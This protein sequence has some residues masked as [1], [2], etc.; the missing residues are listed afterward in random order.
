[1]YNDTITVSNKIITSEDL[2]DIFTK[3]NEQLNH[4][5][6]VND[7]EEQR[8]RMLDHK[9]E[10]WSFKDSHSNLNF[11]INFY[12]S[13]EIKFDNF[14]NFISIY[15][16]RL[17]EIKSIYVHYNLYYSTKEEEQDSIYYQQSISMY[18]YEDSMEVTVALNSK[19]KKMDDIYELIK[20]KVL[21][22]KPKY[23]RII[24]KKKMISYI[25]SLAIGLIPGLIIST[26]LLLVEPIRN[27]YI[28]GIIT[29][30]LVSLII[31]F[32]IGTIITT[33]ILD[34]YYE[35]ISPRRVYDYYDTNKSKSVYKDDIKDFTSKSE[36]LIGKNTNNL[37]CRKK[38]KKMYKKYKKILPYEIGIMLI[39]SLLVIVIK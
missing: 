21:K 10:K 6:K 8:N 7:N 23:D 37:K 31:S 28:N 33:N 39:I 27:I 13:T 19:D 25:I 24:K 16:R 15:N 18:I 30:P 5:R 11:S 1:M 14:N 38:I 32:T 22:A 2:V 35:K 17:G 4:Y 29:Y 3:M 9:Y 36:I 12:D 20:N 34:P 26:L